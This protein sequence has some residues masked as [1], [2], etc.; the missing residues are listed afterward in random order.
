MKPAKAQDLSAAFDYG[1]GIGEVR[2]ANRDPKGSAKGTG[3]RGELRAEF[4]RGLVLGYET[5][6]GFTPAPVRPYR[7]KARGPLVYV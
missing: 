6:R 7:R 5:P 4:A 3:L 1:R 2:R